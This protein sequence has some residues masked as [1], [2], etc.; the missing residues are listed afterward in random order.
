MFVPL[1]IGEIAGKPAPVPAPLPPVFELKWPPSKLPR[2]VGPCSIPLMLACPLDRDVL[3]SL[4]PEPPVAH[5][6]LKSSENAASLIMGSEKCSPL[7]MN[8]PLTCQ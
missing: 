6:V 8:V 1:N 4:E 7:M 3:A 5:F 2:G